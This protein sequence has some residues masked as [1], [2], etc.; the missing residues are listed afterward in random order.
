MEETEVEMKV[1]HDPISMIQEVEQFRKNRQAGKT[2]HQHQKHPVYHE[3][4]FF[5][6]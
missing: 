2:H 3:R 1:P 4:R 6:A 5:R